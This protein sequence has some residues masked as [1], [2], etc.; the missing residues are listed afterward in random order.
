MAQGENFFLDRVHQWFCYQS[1]RAPGSVLGKKLK[2]LKQDLKSWNKKVFRRVHVKKWDFILFFGGEVW[3]W[4]EGFRFFT[5]G[6]GTE[7]AF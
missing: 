4:G 3:W 5:L 6:R 7:A 1:Q 2:A